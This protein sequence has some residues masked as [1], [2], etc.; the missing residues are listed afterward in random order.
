MEQTGKRN[1]HKEACPVC[2]NMES[3]KAREECQRVAALKAAKSVQ[4]RSVPLPAL[5]R[6]AAQSMWNEHKLTKVIHGPADI[7]E[8][9]VHG[10]AAPEAEGA[11]L[12]GINVGGGSGGGDSGGGGSGGGGSG[13][14]GS[15]GGGSGD[16]DG[17]A[18][19]DEEGDG[20]G[21]AA[22]GDEPLAV[23][24]VEDNAD[25]D[26]IAFVLKGDR[27][28]FK[29]AG[30]HPTLRVPPGTGLV[31]ESW[32]Q[33]QLVLS[34]GPA[35]V[36]GPNPHPVA[37]P[38]AAAPS[39]KYM[40]VCINKA[41]FFKPGAPMSWGFANAHCAGT[42]PVSGKVVRCSNQEC[43]ATRNNYEA[44][45]RASVKKKVFIDVHGRK[46]KLA[47]GFLSVRC[48][49]CARAHPLKHAH[50]N[51]YCVSVCEVA[52]LMALCCLMLSPVCEGIRRECH[53][54]LISAPIHQWCVSPSLSRQPLRL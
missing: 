54:A 28:V 53:A 14:G 16:G 23:P 40:Q 4:A 51:S 29:L 3:A 2:G 46:V 11:W 5:R 45:L 30:L 50:T 18:V 44:Q 31:R 47:G 17:I 7:V 38:G 12:P 36:A 6:G 13:G 42:H 41:N 39:E 15:G 21:I 37:L 49:S 8:V 10:G 52:W 19:G 20:G 48:S 32:M 1:R 26:N 33:P 35:L 34:P 22:E 27:P 43:I 24:V 25:I 9:P